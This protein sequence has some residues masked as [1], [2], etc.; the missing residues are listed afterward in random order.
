MMKRM[1]SLMSFV[2]CLNV[3][4]LYITYVDAIMTLLHM[5]ILVCCLGCGLVALFFPLRFPYR[6]VWSLLL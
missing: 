6:T 3:L 4:Y 1:F 2:S 5:V